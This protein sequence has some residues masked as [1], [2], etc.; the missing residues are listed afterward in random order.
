MVQVDHTL[1]ILA[2][3]LPILLY[4]FFIP[5]NNFRTVIKLL[6]ASDLTKYSL[7]KELI[8]K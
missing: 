6:K 5:A 1:F 2:F 8:W 3:K 7:I 4:V